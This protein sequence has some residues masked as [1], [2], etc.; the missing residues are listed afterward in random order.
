MLP[1]PASLHL[2]HF[3]ALDRTY[4]D[5]AH[6]SYTLSCVEWVGLAVRPKPVDANGTDV[7]ALS[8]SGAF[9]NSYIHEKHS[10]LR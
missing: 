7:D 6:T 2:S 8:A 5:A 9:I 1:R 10:N 3:D 4:L